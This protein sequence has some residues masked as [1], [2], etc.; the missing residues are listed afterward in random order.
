MKRKGDIIRKGDAPS[1]E[2]M[3]PAIEEVRAN[4]Y[5]SKIQTENNRFCLPLVSVRRG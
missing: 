5:R 1:L 2:G 4:E 3:S